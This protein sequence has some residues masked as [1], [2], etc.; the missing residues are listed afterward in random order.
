LLGFFIQIAFFVVRTE[1][2]TG[3][4]NMGFSGIS[5]PKLA[6]KK[7]QELFRYLLFTAEMLSY[8]LPYSLRNCNSSFS[9]H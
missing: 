9:N 3:V 8:L 2:S 1:F 4:F 7:P 5:R 6:V